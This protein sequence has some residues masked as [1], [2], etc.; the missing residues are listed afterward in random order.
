MPAMPIEGYEQKE[1]L[2]K[3]ESST[4]IDRLNSVII[5]SDK[6]SSL[7]ELYSST[8]SL[9]SCIND[10]IC[11]EGFD[12]FFYENSLKQLVDFVEKLNA[13]CEDYG[14][15]IT[16]NIDIQKAIDKNL[17]LDFLSLYEKKQIENVYIIFDSSPE[18]VEANTDLFKRIIEIFSR[19]KSSLLIKNK[20]IQP[21][22]YFFGRSGPYCLNKR[23]WQFYSEELKNHRVLACSQASVLVDVNKLL[24][25]YNQDTK[26]FDEFLL[27]VA[28]ALLAANTSQRRKAGEYFRKINDINR[29]FEA[30]FSILSRNYVRFWNYNLG[31]ER[32]REFFLSLLEHSKKKIDA[33]CHTEETIYRSCGM[34]TRFRLAFAC[35]FKEASEKLSEESYNKTEIK[36]FED[37]EK[38]EIK[39]ILGV[40]EAICSIFDGG[41]RVGIYKS[42]N[43]NLDGAI[44]EIV[45]ILKNYKIPLLSYNFKSI[46]GNL[47][48]SH[49]FATNKNTK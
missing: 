37:L 25:E 21:A 17:L 11:L 13:E 22:P 31:N 18:V 24:K 36:S 23:E 16:L 5:F 38:K 29:P 15:K 46:K 44:K 43:I 12:H 19:S 35:A 1:I 30:E 34:P 41:D 27:N 33:F 2:V 14:K 20:E 10:A 48:L 8:V 3:F 6:F 42:E 40:R 49:F 7:N 45:F 28:R 9:F 4:F 26:K 39:K 47:K 32:E